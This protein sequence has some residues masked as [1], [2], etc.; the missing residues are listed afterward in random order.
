[1]IAARWADMVEGLAYAWRTPGVLAL[2]A[3]AFLVNFTAFPWCY[4]LLPYVAR[5]VYGIDATGLSHMTAGFATGALVGS[6]FMTFG[7]S[8]RR[9]ARFMVINIVLWHVLLGIFAWIDTKWPGIAVLFVMG[10]VHS[11]AMVAMSGLL[12][13]DV[14]ERFRARVMGIRM[15][16][17]YGL[18]IGL[19]LT[20][21]LIAHVGFAATATGYITV[22]A[23]LTGLIAWR[24]RETIWR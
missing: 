19:L 6:L 9:D 3:L 17:V 15:L 1:M 8:Q 12:L 18:P 10:L 24:W 21:P 11:L 5:E 2:M 23:L 7:R 13:R 16:A 20:G 14:D 4:S 22:G